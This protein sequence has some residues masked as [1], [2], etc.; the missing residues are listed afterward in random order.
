[1]ALF[2]LTPGKRQYNPGGMSSSFLLILV[3][4]FSIGALLAAW[5]GIRSLQSARSVV[6]YR[7]RQA[8]M[9]AGRQWLGFSVAL[10]LL[11]VVVV[12]LGN[13][14]IG[15]ILSPAQTPTV[16]SSLDSPAD[17]LPGQYRYRDPDLHEGGCHRD[18]EYL[19]YRNNPGD[20]FPDP[21]LSWHVYSACHMD[22]E[23][24]HFHRHAFLHAYCFPN[25]H[26]HLDADAE[27]H[28]AS[29]YTASPTRTSRPTITLIPT[30]TPR[31]TWTSLPHTD[32]RDTRALRELPSPTAGAPRPTATSCPPLPHAPRPPHPRNCGHSSH[33][34][35]FLWIFVRVSL[36]RL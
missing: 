2:Y 6:F 21:T 30:Q 16:S 9:M 29:T 17:L 1:M 4:V 18:I 31:P 10:V 22:R 3:L 14:M 5:A 25:A 20:A 15:W 33:A 27:Q 28:A 11:A 23:K 26:P 8:R 12:T 19:C 7:T 13:S 35:I 34:I 36:L 32:T 24:K